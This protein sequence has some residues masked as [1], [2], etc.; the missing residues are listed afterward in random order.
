MRI[1]DWSSDVCSSDLEP[2]AGSLYQSHWR[3]FVTRINQIVSACFLSRSLLVYCEYLLMET[4][5]ASCYCFGFA[6]VNFLHD[7]SP[8]R[9][10]HLPGTAIDVDWMDSGDNLGGLCSQPI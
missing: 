10:R 5:Y 6:L 3:A 1:S 8:N 4:K 7:W 9:W 2:S